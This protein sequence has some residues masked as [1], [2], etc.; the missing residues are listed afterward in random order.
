[1]QVKE[2]MYKRYFYISLLLTVLSPTL[3]KSSL[4]LDDEAPIDGYK[5]RLCGIGDLN[6][7]GNTDIIAQQDAALY[8]HLQSEQGIFRNATD[9]PIGINVS[10]NRASCFVG[11]F[12]GDTIADILVVEG[13]GN[14][15]EEKFIA[16]IIFM[17]R[18]F[19]YNITKIEHIFYDEPI[20]V[21][22]DGDG[23]SDIIGFDFATQKMICIG[24]ETSFQSKS[25][26]NLFDHK[27]FE[28]SS[29]F[30]PIRYFPHIF[31]DFDGDLKAD[32]VFGYK[33]ETKVVLVMYR[34]RQSDSM[35]V[36]EE[37][38]IA[39]MPKEYDERK[40]ASP[41][42]SDF[43]ADGHLDIA[44]PICSDDNCKKI[45]KFI[46]WSNKGDKTSHGEYFYFGVDSKESDL[47]MSDI[48]GKI[49]FRV[50]D[51]N[52]DGFPDL[53]AVAKI[54]NGE[55]PVILE[56]IECSGCG[57]NVTRKFEMKTTQRL[58]EPSNMSNGQVKIAAFFDLK[59]DGNLDIMAEYTDATGDTRHDFIKCDDKGDTTFMK[60]QIYTDVCQSNCPKPVLALGG[61]G[62]AW[63]GACA[64]YSMTDSWG[65]LKQSMKCQMPQ[66]NQRLFM[67]P[68]ILF[69]LGRSPNYINEFKL[70][71]P[72]KYI[73]GILLS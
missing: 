1:M 53:V 60:V 45:E 42:V 55:H 57:G 33:I 11:D 5:G 21:D 64:Y 28:K 25:C 20:V 14:P 39:K 67:G 40:L 66:T 31:A 70:G 7:D 71:G 4:I 2:T 68:Y 34:M 63:H 37:N 73:P 27:D 9:K 41:I 36:I 44:F 47:V 16:S 69:G 61:S 18:N 59:E 19:N 15:K 17:D 58:I 56:S 8:L 72:Y 49:M 43:D 51:F 22:I 23:M 24:G 35:W 6:K 26:N 48:D 12:N 3:V 62:V 38:A 50:G 30:K 32:L 65:S 29:K 54:N 52:L 46:I 10:T 13:S